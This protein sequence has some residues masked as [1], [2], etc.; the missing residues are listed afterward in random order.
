MVVVIGI[1]SVVS[2]IT[3]YFLINSL[4]IYTMTVNQKTLLDEGKLALER[5]CRDIRDANNISF[6]VS[7]GSAHLITFSRTNATVQY[8]ASETITFQLT[9]NNLQRVKTSPSAISTLAG[10]VSTFTVTRDTNN[11]IKLLLTLSLGTGESVALQTKVYPK[12]LV[13]SV[14]YKNFFNNWLEEI[15][16]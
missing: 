4:K 5:M 10:N 14:T 3:I 12:N 13:D 6:P 7:R 16:R 11:E 1:L 15:S 8:S 9:G 2:S